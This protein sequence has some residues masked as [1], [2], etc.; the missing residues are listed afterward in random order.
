MV[1]HMFID[2]CLMKAA[3]NN[4]GRCLSLGP[5]PKSTLTQGFKGRAFV[6]E[7]FSIDTTGGKMGE[8]KKSSEPLSQGQVTSCS[9][10]GS[11]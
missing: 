9:Q 4:S 7:I 11:V 6:W 2:M 8:G 10:L 5:L 3:K 1:T